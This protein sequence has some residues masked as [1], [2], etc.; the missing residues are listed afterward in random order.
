LVN[1]AGTELRAKCG[2][3]EITLAETAEVKASVPSKPEA[4]RLYA[5]GLAKLRFFDASRARDLLE[6]ATAADPNFALAHWALAEAWS[7]LGYNQKAREEAEK[8]FD[9]SGNLSRE[10]RLV[11][12][13]RYRESI[14][15]WDK[16]FEAYK[17][18]HVLFSDNLEYGLHLAQAQDEAGKS[19]DALATLRLLRKLPLPSGEDPRIDLNEADVGIEGFE[20]VKQVQ[21]LAAKAAAKA[22]ALGARRL[23]AEARTTEGRALQQENLDLAQAR[24]EDA[25]T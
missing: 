17:S 10:S 12:E 25:K 7:D 6:K 8:A 20:D 16:A 4:S 11:I 9:L 1:R 18:L 3:E 5:E 24:Y 23:V 19:K 22:T 15:D 2:A 13:G 14:Y 21:A